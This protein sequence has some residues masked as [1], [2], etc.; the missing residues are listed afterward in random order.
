MEW[1]WGH[2]FGSGQLHRRPA[3]V[4]HEHAALRA[5]HFVIE[6]DAD[7]GI[8]P[9]L[10]RTFGHFAHGSLTRVRKLL[11]ISSRA[12][13][14]DIPDS[15]EQIAEQVGAEDGFAGHESKI[16]LDRPAIDRWC[17][18]EDHGSS[19]QATASRGRRA[20]SRCRMRSRPAKRPLPVAKMTRSAQSSTRFL[21]TIK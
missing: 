9:E 3:R 12:S 15:S 6:I 5:Q 13:A 19:H 7:D 14:N 16:G 21:L 20:K 1:R 10:L 17:G 18:G 11:L 2:S 4:H 8:G